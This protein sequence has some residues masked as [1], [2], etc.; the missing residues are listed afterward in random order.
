MSHAPMASFF[1]R[2][3]NEL[4]SGFDKERVYPVLAIDVVDDQETRF[5]LSNTAGEFAWVGM[6]DVRRASKADSAPNQ[7]YNHKTPPHFRSPA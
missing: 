4:P 5:L 7:R 2:F 3:Q 1:V 6:S